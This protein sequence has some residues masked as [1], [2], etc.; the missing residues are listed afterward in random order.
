MK[1]LPYFKFDSAE[2]ITGNITLEGDEVQ[3][4]FINVCAH[5]WIK[6]GQLK[7]SEI[8]RRL[9]KSKPTA[10]ESLIKNG[11]IKVKSDIISIS[12]LDAQLHERGIISKVNSENGKLGGRPKKRNESETKATALNSE[13]EKKQ[14]RGEEKR[15]EEKRTEEKRVECDPDFLVF[16]NWSK[17]IISGNDFLFAQKFRNEFPNWGGAPELF[18]EVV[19]DHLD[20]LNRYPKMNP[21][22]QERFRNSVI[23]HFR[24]Y[25][26]K[27]NGTG[28]KK[29]FDSEGAKNSIADYIAKHG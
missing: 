18:V 7:L 27:P 17:D 28:T 4:L 6:S 1:E 19:N 12:F 20:L 10:F 25:K 14:Y 26:N 21:N 3:G 13:S 23:K 29:G 5:Y 16:E 15:V 9:S 24:E 11:H 2:W 22:S 8:K